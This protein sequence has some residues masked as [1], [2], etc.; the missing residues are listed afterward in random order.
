MMKKKIGNEWRVAP[1]KTSLLLF[2]DPSED[3]QDFQKLRGSGEE[4]EWWA[5][6]M[7]KKEEQ[8]STE[9][10]SKKKSCNVKYRIYRTYLC[11]SF[12]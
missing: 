3:F 4:V 5:L 8:K 6:V 7:M 11:S 12:F 10:T 2:H 9:H 1:K